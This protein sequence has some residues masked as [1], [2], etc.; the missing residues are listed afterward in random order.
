MLQRVLRLGHH[1]GAAAED[2]LVVGAVDVDVHA[3]LRLERLEVDPC[4][5][6]VY[7]GCLEGV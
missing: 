3:V 4:Y 5:V 7:L 2:E 1:L 6:G